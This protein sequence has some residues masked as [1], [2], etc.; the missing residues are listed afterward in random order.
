MLEKKI[1]VKEVY[2]AMINSYD[3]DKEE[4]YNI[5]WKLPVP[6]ETKGLVWRLAHDRLQTKDNLHKRLILPPG[7]Q[8]QCVMRMVWTRCYV[9]IG[10]IRVLPANYLMH[11]WQHLGGIDGNKAKL[12]WGAVWVSIVWSIWKLRN[13]IIFNNAACNLQSLIDE[14]RYRAWLWCKTYVKDFNFTLYV[15]CMDPVNCIS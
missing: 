9:W 6:S 5:L 15:W 2:E 12:V 10:D 14:S 13:D 7:F 11:F 1:V 3:P 4:F 8:V